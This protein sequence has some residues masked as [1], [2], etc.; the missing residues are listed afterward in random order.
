MKN[1]YYSTAYAAKAMLD[2]WVEN[3]KGP[4]STTAQQEPQGHT[5][6]KMVF[7]NSAAAFLGIPGSVAYT[8]E[9]ETLVNFNMPLNSCQMIY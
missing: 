6:R 2:I 7:I 4:S 1:N 9:S 5:T 3:D 8:R